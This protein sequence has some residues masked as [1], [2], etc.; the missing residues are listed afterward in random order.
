VFTLV[1]SFGNG[2]KL[3]ITGMFSLFSVFPY[4]K[5][6]SEYCNEDKLISLAYLRLMS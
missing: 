5:Q 3:G 2:F 4:Q 1:E 6:Y